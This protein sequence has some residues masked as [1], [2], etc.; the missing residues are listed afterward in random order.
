MLPGKL[1]YHA[2][3]LNQLTIQVTRWSDLDA[4][5]RRWIL[6]HYRIRHV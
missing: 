1:A 2:A 5:Q 3:M 4:L 6:L